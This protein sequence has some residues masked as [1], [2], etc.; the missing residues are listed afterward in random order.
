MQNK[1]LDRRKALYLAFSILVAS[2]IWVY[3][4][5]V[6]GVNGKQSPRI[7]RPTISPS[8]TCFPTAATT[9]R[10]VWRSGD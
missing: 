9:W 3:A 7:R 2:V 1:K 5:A 6:V 4:D 10:T 8:S